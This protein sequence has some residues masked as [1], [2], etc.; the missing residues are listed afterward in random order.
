MSGVEYAVPSQESPGNDMNWKA[1]R[2]STV[3]STSIR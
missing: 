2:V 1:S 3:G